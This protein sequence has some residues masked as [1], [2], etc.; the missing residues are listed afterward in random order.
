MIG[1]P[2]A[3]D[4]WRD[5]DWLARNGRPPPAAEKRQGRQTEETCGKGQERNLGAKVPAC[6][7]QRNSRLQRR[8]CKDRRSGI[9]EPPGLSFLDTI[10]AETPARTFR[11][12]ALMDEGRSPSSTNRPCVS[13]GLSAEAAH[14]ARAA[15]R[16]L[17]RS[18]IG[19]FNASMRALT[20]SRAVKCDALERSPSVDS[21]TS[22]RAV[23]PRG[24]YSR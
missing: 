3:T 15:A 7:L 16:R 14:S 4:A 12:H 13:S 17:P 2:R 20:S 21:S 1:A 11:H 9:I 22:S 19:S 23:R 18:S 8:S 6:P 5:W 24:K 10:P